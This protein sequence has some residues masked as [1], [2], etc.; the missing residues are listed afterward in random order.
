VGGESTVPGP[1]R[2]HETIQGVVKLA[3]QAR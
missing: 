1:Q 3:H 2:L